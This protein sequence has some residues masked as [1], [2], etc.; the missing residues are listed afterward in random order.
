M[1]D[2]IF[3]ELKRRNVYKV[4]FA[5]LVLAWVVVQVTQ[6]AVPAFNMPDWM[7]TVVF[8][9]GVI[10]FPFALFFAWAFEITPDGIKK[11]SEISPEESIAAH[12]G[13]KLDFIII[14]LLIVGMTYFIYESRFESNSS[15]SVT[16]LTVEMKGSNKVSK[17]PKNASIAALSLAVLPF[18]NMS[19]DKKQDYFV[20]GLT[21]EL[22]NSLA[23]IK[24]LKVTGRTSSFAY[25][26]KNIDLRAIA[27][28]LNVNYLVEGSVRKSGE[29]IR[30]TVQLIDAD[31]GAHL[32]SD[33]FNRKL[34]DIFAVQEEVSQQVASA[35]KLNLLYKDN[36]YSSALESL[37][38]IAV[39]QLVKAR[40]LAKLYNEYGINQ[41]KAILISLNE[42]YPDT[43]EIMGLSVFTAMLEISATANV[44]LTSE[45]LIQL[46][47]R[48]LELQPSNAD[49]LYTLAVI[50]DDFEQTYHLAAE[51]Y[52]KGIQQ[53]PSQEQFHIGYFRLMRLQYIPCSE[54]LTYLDSIQL[55]MLSDELSNQFRFSTLR[56]LDP[57]AAER[58]QQLAT[59][60]NITK[61]DSPHASALEAFKQARARYQKNPNQRFLTG[62][63]GYYSA[64]NERGK[65]KQLLQQVDFNSKG[66]WAGFSFVGAYF[67]G[68]SLPYM[69]MDRLFDARQNDQYYDLHY[70]YALVMWDLAKKEEKTSAFRRRILAL[71]PPQ[72]SIE[73]L[74]MTTPYLTLLHHMGDRERVNHYTNNLLPKLA[75]YRERH[76]ESYYYYKL[77][78]PHFVLATL[79]ENF[80]LAQQ[81]LDDTP[82]D[83]EYWVYGKTAKYTFADKLNVPVI[84]E[85]LQKIKTD[86]KRV[87][88]EL[89]FE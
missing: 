77:F 16:D 88:K 36:Y 42:Q 10:G 79:A 53:Y 23:R 32:F 87:R 86:T 30:I 39:E 71:E 81:L 59:T 13:R 64:L 41:A 7:N 45:D 26:N 55:N 14:G 69:S 85:F 28:E 43:P 37:D 52:K 27:K 47:Q 46:A 33:I 5:Y 29:N 44:T 35:L 66:F 74:R 12:T 50:F 6:A 49:S 61:F 18:V 67:D 83:H 65:V 84:K 17:D 57:Q 48:T 31:S 51:Y 78:E 3:S 24:G 34:V 60:E 25:K 19:D 72:W 70:Q 58:L 15:E 63:I 68:Y 40:A 89:G 80:S 73:H 21:E 4:G 38:Y 1:S 2:S 82:Q 75:D 76:P 62:L 9:L 20:D 54:I 56:C 11:E 22:L 8:F